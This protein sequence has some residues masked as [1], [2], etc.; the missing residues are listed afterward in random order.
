MDYAMNG[1][2]QTTLGNRHPT[3][4]A[5]RVSVRPARRRWR[6]LDSH[7]DFRRPRLGVVR[8][9]HRQPIV[10]RAT[11][12]FATHQSRRANHDALDERISSWTRNVGHIEAMSLL[13]TH[14]VAAGAVLNQRDASADPHLQA[15]GM[16]EQAWQQDVGTHLYPRAPFKMSES[17]RP[18]TTRPRASGTG[19]R[20]RL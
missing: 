8:P 7:Y 5:G 1:R 14:G 2:S 4:L 16:F 15:R 10:G 3:A 12:D 9:G 13:Q 6:R 11:P 18:H 17:G 19:Q 20:V